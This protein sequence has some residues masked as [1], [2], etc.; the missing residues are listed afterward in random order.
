MIKKSLLSAL[1]VATILAGLGWSQSSTS[2]TKSFSPRELADTRQIATIADQTLFQLIQ[3]TTAGS[4]F[5]RDSTYLVFLRQ[6]TPV[7]V[8]TFEDSQNPS[9]VLYL[10]YVS[11]TSQHFFLQIAR[12]PDAE[13]HELL[14][15][16]RLCS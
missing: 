12:N 1:T 8:V 13:L 2:S 3:A 15:G 4:I 9:K 5:P 14:F 11:N 16:R 7:S 6:S 10:Y